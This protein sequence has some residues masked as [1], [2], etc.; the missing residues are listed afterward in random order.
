MHSLVRPRLALLCQ[1]W[2]GSKQPEAGSH[3]PNRARHRDGALFP[4][5]QDF[6]QALARA[7]TPWLRSCGPEVNE[8]RTRTESGRYVID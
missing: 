7:P 6:T 8:T 1:L 3:A 2:Q 4:E 5:P